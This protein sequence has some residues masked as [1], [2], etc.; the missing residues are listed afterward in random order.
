M[1]QSEARRSS[2]QLVL[3]ISPSAAVMATIWSTTSALLAAESMVKNV[4]GL[5]SRGH[6]IFIGVD[7]DLHDL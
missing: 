6:S 3:P 1:F 4:F 2:S 5:L 7:C